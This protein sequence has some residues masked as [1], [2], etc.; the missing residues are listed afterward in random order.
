M[1]R[2]QQLIHLH[3][4]AALDYAKATGASM[5]LG[6][7]AVRHATGT[8]DT[9][10]VDSELYI[11]NGN[12][13]A[14]GEGRI[15]SFPSKAYVDAQIS[16]SNGDISGLQGEVGN[17]ETA[18]GLNNDG[19]IAAW[20]TGATY[21]KD[22]ATFKAAIEALDT[23]AKANAAAAAAAKSVVTAGDN[24][25]VTPTT[26]DNGAVTY[27][28]AATGLVTT[29]TFTGFKTN[30]VGQTGVDG[31]SA[32]VSFTGKNYI[33]GATNLKAA[34][35]ALDGQA[36]K[37][38]DDAANAA[39]EAAK[40]SIVKGTGNITVTSSGTGQLTYTVDGSKLATVTDLT[41]L[42]NRVVTIEEFFNGAAEDS[43]ATN[44]IDTLKE[45]Q[46]YI[47][48][49]ESGA[50]AMT[51]KL[52]NITEVL[53]GY[54]KTGETGSNTVI[55]NII[56]GKAETTALAAVET[57][58]NHIVGQTGVDGA[59]DT[60]TFT[61]TNYLSNAKTLK[62]AIVELDTRAKA[63]A[64]EAAKHTEVSGA[65]N[66]TVTSNTVDGKTTYTVDGKDLATKTALSTAEGKIATIE[67]AYVKDI[68]IVNST[69][70]GVTATKGT[71]SY[72][73]NFDAMVID[74]GEY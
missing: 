61:S 48:T 67:G 29:D 68:T 34:I 46:D 14:T 23:R 44:V 70:R 30:I 17:I 32:A 71:N 58:V 53:G 19:T 36:K 20:A 40:H 50:A 27:K 5:A 65:N 56:D 1:A 41:S 49:D 7:I 6:E 9:A 15:V 64:T 47:A 45:I 4:A 31:N 51:A 57:T 72:A 54:L 52:A 38:A 16:A 18:V 12:T 3:S 66:I 35:E 24:I 21:I 33:S 42:T 59:S 74:C 25:A 22:T 28:V 13:G 8:G 11:L 69:A 63:N 39:T 73:I 55:K 43:G 10:N 37:N 60:V 62:A 2:K 26:G